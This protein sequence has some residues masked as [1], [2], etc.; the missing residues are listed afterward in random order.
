HPS[1]GTSL[2]RDDSVMIMLRE[3]NPSKVLALDLS[4]FLFKCI[5]NIGY[6]VRSFL[7]AYPI[8]PFVSLWALVTAPTLLLRILIIVFGVAIFAFST[9]GYGFDRYL[10]PFYPLILV[11]T[12][13]SL[14]DRNWEKYAPRLAPY[15]TWIFLIV[16][17]SALAW[18]YLQS[19]R[20]D[21]QGFM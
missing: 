5:R 11:M 21:F 2:S 13:P 3:M 15:R 7:Q 14:I 17:C 20:N 18:N 4:G 12:V 16:I 9:G 1:I 6:Y 10:T 19:S 8:L